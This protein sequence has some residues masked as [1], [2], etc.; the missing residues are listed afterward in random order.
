MV[1]D[2]FSNSKKEEGVTV[3]DDDIDDFSVAWSKVDPKATGFIPVTRVATLLRFA[4]PPLG[5]RGTKISRLGLLCVLRV[6]PNPASLFAYAR[7]TL[8]FSQSQT[9]PEKPQPESRE[10]LSALPGHATGGHREGDGNQHRA[11]PDGGA[12]CVGGG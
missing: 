5:V 4:A 10:Q 6:S 1:L 3:T 2:N 7:L 8:L 11:T 12:N 9:V